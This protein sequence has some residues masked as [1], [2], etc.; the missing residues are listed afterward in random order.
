L[1]V[2]FSVLEHYYG[3]E[4]TFI[5]SAVVPTLDEIPSDSQMSAMFPDASIPYQVQYRLV[6]EGVMDALPRLVSIEEAA[7]EQ[8]SA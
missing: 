4:Y 5:F 7:V 2:L 3:S 8:I 6:Q 1:K